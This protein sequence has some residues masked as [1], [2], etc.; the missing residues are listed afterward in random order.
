MEYMRRTLLGRE[1]GTTADMTWSHLPAVAGD[2]CHG[3]QAAAIA[4]SSR[5][6][7]VCCSAEAEMRREEG[8]IDI[9]VASTSPK[10]TR[11]E[12]LVFIFFGRQRKMKMKE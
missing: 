6:P 8:E 2:P 7:A 10:R 9:I 5:R 12:G 11:A 1:G 3:T 4:R